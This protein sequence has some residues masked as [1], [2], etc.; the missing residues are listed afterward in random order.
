MGIDDNGYWSL[1]EILGYGA[2]WNAVLSDR[3]RGKTYTTKRFLWQQPGEFM[4]VYRQKPDMTSSVDSW[5]DTLAEQKVDCSG[6]T[7][8]GNDAAGYQLMDNGEIRGY[9]RCLSA[10]NRIKQEK[11]PDTLNWMW[12]DEFIPLAWTKLPGIDS[13]GDALRTIYRTIDHDSAHPR[14]SK[15][16]KP[17]RVLMY[18]NP[19]TWDNPL[20]S[21]FKID[22]LRGVGVHRVSKDIVYEILP[23]L[24]RTDNTSEV[25]GDEVDRNMAF[26]SQGS[27]CS[28]I[29]KGAKP[30]LSVRISSEFYTFYEAHGSTWVKKRREH[31]PIQSR[32]SGMLIQFGT[33]DGLREEERCLEDTQYPDRLRRMLY[34]GQLQFES[35]NTKFDFMRALETVK[36]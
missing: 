26:L 2:I 34:R 24:E 16:L 33:L 25:L 21:Y 36:R 6:L 5:W 20:L 35:M 8:D 22:P 3:G 14:E 15:G 31:T 30:V 32:R 27:F 13:E 10:V 1:R 9:F 23:P 28:P 4:C 12:W 19:M 29:P 11:F 7:W 17:L 18:G